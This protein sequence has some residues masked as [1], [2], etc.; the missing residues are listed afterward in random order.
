MAMV[1][2]ERNKRLQGLAAQIG[3]ELGCS[4]EQID[5]IKALA[6]IADIGHIGIEDRLLKN[7]INLHGKDNSDYLKHV[8]IGRSLIAGISEISELESLYLDIYK[9]YDEWKEGISLSARI[10]AGAIGFDDI[11]LNCSTAR[12]KN[13]ISLLEKQKGAK[14]CPKVVDALISVTSKHPA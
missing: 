14:Y 8:E 10:V 2:I 9:R 12:M 1:A 7:R 13:I 5:E 3:S 4:D 6:K 11:S